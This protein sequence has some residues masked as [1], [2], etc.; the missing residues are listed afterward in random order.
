[1]I[2]PLLSFSHFFSFGTYCSNFEIPWYMLAL[3]LVWQFYYIFSCGR[4]PSPFSAVSKGVFDWQSGP[5][6][7]QIVL[8]FWQNSQ[9]DSEVAGLRPDLDSARSIT[10]ISVCQNLQTL[11][12]S[13]LELCPFAGVPPMRYRGCQICPWQLVLEAINTRRNCNRFAIWWFFVNTF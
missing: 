10:L 13:I 6:V 8:S 1:M 2:H 12:I 5:L 7:Y 11:N 4:S 9:N 3:S